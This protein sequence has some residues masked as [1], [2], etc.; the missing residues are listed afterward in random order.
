M[1]ALLRASGSR[2]P[3]FGVQFLTGM[4]NAEQAAEVMKMD[5]TDQPDPMLEEDILDPNDSDKPWDSHKGQT[6]IHAHPARFEDEGQ[7]GG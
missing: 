3:H 1:A 6:R 2:T 5:L 7:S 4:A